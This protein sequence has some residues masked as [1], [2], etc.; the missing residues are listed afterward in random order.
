[1]LSEDQWSEIRALHRD[2]VPIKQIARKLNIAPN[3]VR[4][5][6]KTDDPP[7][8]RRARLGPASWNCITTT[9]RT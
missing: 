8:T 3:T 1:M 7:V 5:A 9:S 6:I 2:H 4:R